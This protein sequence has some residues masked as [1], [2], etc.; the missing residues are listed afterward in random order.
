MHAAKTTGDAEKAA[1]FKRMKFLEGETESMTKKMMAVLAENTGL[2]D[3]ERLRKA[4]PTSEVRQPTTEGRPSR[5]PSE[6]YDIGGDA[7]EEGSRWTGKP[8]EDEEWCYAPAP[9]GT[10]KVEAPTLTAT[11]TITRTTTHPDIAAGSRDGDATSANS[12]P[13]RPPTPDSGPG[14]DGGGDGRGSFPSGK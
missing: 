5:S 6:Y 12:R 7:E 3:R 13:K 8:Y 11:Q 4:M 1:M 2:H 14:G 10:T 9:T